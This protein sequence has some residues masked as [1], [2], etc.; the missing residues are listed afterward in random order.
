MPKQHL[1]D[2]KQIIV[3]NYNLSIPVGGNA[4]ILRAFSA[5]KKQDKTCFFLILI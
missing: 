3:S 4:Y 1:I 5:R 2:I